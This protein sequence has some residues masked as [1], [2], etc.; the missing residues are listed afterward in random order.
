MKILP[1]GN[2]KKRASIEVFANESAAQNVK[3]HFKPGQ[4]NHQSHRTFILYNRTERDDN[5]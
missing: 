5:M 4:H 1:D 3:E 2:E